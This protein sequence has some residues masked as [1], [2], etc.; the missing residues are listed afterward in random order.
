MIDTIVVEE[1]NDVKKIAGLQNGELREFVIVEKDKVNE[2]NIYVGK[3]VKKISTAN[4]NEGYFINIGEN[5]DVFLNAEEYG[6]EPLKASEGQDVVVQ[7]Q[8]EQR[9]EKG[10]RMT[11]FLHLAGVY[12]VYSPYGDEI[13]VS[14]KIQDETVRDDLGQFVDENATDGGW[15]VRTFAEKAKKEDIA[16]EIKNLQQ[17]FDNIMMKAKKEKAPCLLLAKDNAL[18]EMICR[19]AD[20][21][22]KM[23]V[24]NHLLEN[25][26][27]NTVLTEYCKDAFAEYG[28]DDMIQE[29][30]M[31]TIK[32]K[33]GGRVI[34]EE[35]KAFVAVDVDSGEGISQGSFAKLN[36]EAAEEIAKQIVLRNLSGKIIIDFAGV[37]EFRFLKNVMDL[38]AAK[39]Q[40]DVCKARVLGLSRAGNVEVVRN[41]RRPSLRDLL[42]EDCNVC[43][44]TGRVEK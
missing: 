21:L 36:M 41:R 24:N 33:S 3:I 5:R 42:T 34:I 10:A 20:G 9:A 25:E 39:L 26:F 4:G 43:Q 7:V 44:A 31:K 38:L 22:Q 35:T 32:L 6:L 16:D 18:Q 29:A 40:N 2:G 27:K 8:Q 19:N 17:L 30:L 12:T 28:I 13:E 37:S 1:K 15:V 23:V 11:R 14:A